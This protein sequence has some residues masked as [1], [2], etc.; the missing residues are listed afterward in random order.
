[1]FNRRYILHTIGILLIAE[2][3]IMLIPFIVSLIYDEGD[4]TAHI[5]SS[6]ITFLAG[7][8]L[9]ILNRTSNKEFGKRE[10]YVIVTIVWVIF[11]LFGS[12]PY[13]LS[14]SIPRFTDA[15]FETISGFT[16]TGASILSNIEALPH[17][18]LFWRSL[19]HFIGGIGIL[20]LAIV[21]L[22]FF[23][24]GGM[25]LFQAETSSYSQDRL[26]PRIKESA[27]RISRIYLA[28][29]F[30]ETL[31][32]V[33]GKMSFFDALCHSFGT[34]A[35]GGFSTKNAGIAAF[36]PYTQYV[37]MFFMV[38][39]GTN[40]TLFFFLS[41][42]KIK[43]IFENQEYKLYL[44]VLLIAG[45]ITAFS[46]WRFNEYS[47]ENAVR[48]GFFQVISIVT[49]TGFVTDN[50]MNWSH[51]LWFIIFVLMFFGASAGSTSGGIKMIRYLIAMKN[52]K[53]QFMRIIHPNAVIP[54]QIN[55]KSLERGIISRVFAFFMLYFMFFGIGTLIM[56][57]LGLDLISAMGS[58][59][60]TMGGIGP[61]LGKVGPIE[62]FGFIHDAGKWVLSFLML[63]GRLELFTVLLLFYPAFWKAK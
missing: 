18:I 57:L 32:L 13:I 50:Y 26:H 21:V 40:F 52:I 3:I 2:S 37:I 42:F 20:V 58:V 63:L 47:L 56:Q 22:P 27:K 34:I 51:Y 15:F 14:D 4:K 8:L 53:I 41:K 28:L 16:T 17:G 48:S 33:A 5:L 11:S 1:M 9:Y 38:F 25:Q 45:T 60:T 43:K 29:I 59:A 35:S 30:I 31:F 61:G 54:V 7:F 36:S 49:S 12:L 24:M 10:A 46:L 55:K 62:N 39:A 19:T 6:L 44:S 23:G